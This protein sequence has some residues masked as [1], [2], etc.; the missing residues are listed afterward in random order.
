MGKGPVPI[1][2]VMAVSRMKYYMRMDGVAVNTKKAFTF[3]KDTVL[4]PKYNINVS[5]INT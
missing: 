5:Y 4:L 2:K 1:Q 3:K